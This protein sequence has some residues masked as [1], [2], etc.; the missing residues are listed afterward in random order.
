MLKKG[1]KRTLLGWFLVITII[2]LLVSGI[3]KHYIT[4]KVLTR[5]IK[6]ALTESAESRG[7]EI[8]AYFS[9][10]MTELQ[11]QAASSE[12]SRVLQ[13]FI[14]AFE[15]SGKSLAKFPKSYPWQKI[16]Q[17]QTNDLKV[18]SEFKG[19]Y[20]I[21]LIDAD[22]N[23]L[24]SVMQESDLGTNLFNGKYS[25]TLFGKLCKKVFD[26]G[27]PLFSDFEFYEPSNNEITGF[28]ADILLD[29]N[30]EKIGLIAFQIDLRKMNEIVRQKNKSFA[31]YD[32]YLVGE[33]LLMRSNSLLDEKDTALV[34]KVNT[35]QTQLWL[36]EHGD[37][38]DEKLPAEEELLIYVGR[39]GKRVIGIHEDLNIFGITMGIFSEINT[40]EA[41]LPL[42]RL[43][44]TTLLIGIIAFV[45]VFILGSVVSKNISKPLL[46]LQKGVETIG[47]GNLDFKVGINAQNEIGS[48][49]QSF[50]N[51]TE[52]LKEARNKLEERKAELE[53]TNL[54]LDSFVYT[55]SHDLR[56]PLRGI[57]SFS[58]F[59]KKGYGDKLDEK[60]IHYLER[61]SKGVGRMTNLI[62][63]LLALSRISR[64]KNPYEEVDINSTLSEV[65]ERIEFDIKEHNADLVI[66]ESLPKIVCDRIKISEV[67]LNL[68]NNGIKFSTKKNKENL[69]IEVG[70]KDDGDYHRFFVK[71]NGIG[72]EPKYHEQIFGIF[73]RLHDSSEYEGTGAGLSIVKRVVDDH[74]GKIWIE[75]EL[76]KGATFFFTIPKDIM[77]KRKKIGEILVEDGLIDEEKL[78]EELDKQEES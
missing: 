75:S 49:S 57:S 27:K 37:D 65:L 67:F 78:K 59:L 20:D 69:K 23:L 64:L 1:L 44:N 2:P 45:L 19:Y 66:Q 42:I 35:E 74:N 32:T 43:R 34:E 46:D 72:I 71:D 62:D 10:I 12:N 13:E 73:K 26:T 76:G 30:G 40:D 52:K 14:S 29:E 22:G 31:T 18:L 3:V 60:G 7:K 63:D 28:L 58:E 61:I 56:A 5:T 4:S 36:K 68:I 11:M 8:K 9:E 6:N 48:L 53:K 24:F 33:D 21:F 51:M 41:F 16:T 38:D 17:H 70:Y 15:Q 39:K 55:A 50:D 47:A 25:E 54:E 77:K